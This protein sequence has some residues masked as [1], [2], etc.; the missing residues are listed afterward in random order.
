MSTMIG[1]VLEARDLDTF[2][3]ASHILRGVNFRVG[4]GET[5]SLLGPTR[6]FTPRKIWLAP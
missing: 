2:Y 5:V 3:G 4:P 6:K 1:N